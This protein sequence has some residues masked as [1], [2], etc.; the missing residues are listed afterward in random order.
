MQKMHMTQHMAMQGEYEGNRKAKAQ[1]FAYDTLDVQFSGSSKL[2]DRIQ[3]L[4]G[5]K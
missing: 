3:R 5:N 1:D 4:G 2:A